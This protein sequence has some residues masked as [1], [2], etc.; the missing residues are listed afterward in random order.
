MSFPFDPV[1]T[2]Y[3]LNGGYVVVSLEDEE[4]EATFH[5]VDGDG[6]VITQ[7][8]TL[9]EVLDSGHVFTSSKEVGSFVEKYLTDIRQAG[10]E[11]VEEG[12]KNG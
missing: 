9:N 8:V 10:A 11:D 12:M 2:I 5:G 3:A 4:T 7:S 1:L 6:E